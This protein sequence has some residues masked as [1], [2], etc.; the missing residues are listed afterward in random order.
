M[1][2]KKELQSLAD[3][4]KSLPE[5]TQMIQSRKRIMSAPHLSRIMQ[6]FEREHTYIL[7]LDIP[8]ADID[9]KLKKLYNDSRDFLDKPEISEYIKNVQSYH[10]MVSQSISYLNSLL[11]INK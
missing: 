1:L 7:N 8:Q 6:L 11:D 3:A 2:P 4:I 9:T 10:S 5:Y